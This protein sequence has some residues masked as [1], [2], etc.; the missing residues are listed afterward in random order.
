MPGRGGLAA[1]RVNSVQDA[2]AG[3]R[4][5]GTMA[6]EPAD[7]LGVQRCIAR[8]THFIDQRRWSELRA[9]YAAH[10]ETDYTS[11]FGGTPVT[12]AG[13][14]LIEG[15]QQALRG[16]TTQHILGPVD[17]EVQGDRARAECHVRGLHLVPGA[18]GGEQWEVMGH[19]VFGLAR[20][21]GGWAIGSM[22]LETIAQTGNRQLLA[23]AAELGRSR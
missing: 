2:R 3:A 9:L 18:P 20:A 21:G 23:E 1:L 19:Y 16:V 12:Q 8:V 17:V 13:D 7:I 6:S 10:V 11:L 4:Y 22:T 14:A 5:A 15:W